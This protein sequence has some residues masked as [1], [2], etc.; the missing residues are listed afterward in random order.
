MNLCDEGYQNDPFKE[1]H[2]PVLLEML[3]I[4]YSGAG[5]ACLAVCYNKSL[6][7]SV[8]MQLDIPVPL[9]TYM[10]S[11]DQTA[12]LPSI[13]PAILKPNFGDS[14]IGIT[15][16]AVVHS[17]EELIIYMNELKNLLPNIPILVQE[18][19]TGSE[20]SVAVIGNSGNYTVLPILEVDYS[21]LP[22]NLPPILGYESKWLPDS[23]YWSCIKYKEAV[24]KEDVYAQLV[25]NAILLFERL[26]CR[27]YARFDFREDEQKNIK[28][29]EVNPNPGWCWDGKMNIMAGF[30]GLSYDQFLEL[31]LKAAIERTKPVFK[32]AT[33]EIIAT[34]NLEQK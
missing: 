19:L 12:T 16:D 23:P 29:L 4:P 15:K 34:E 13:F 17:A 28:L 25:N 3:N 9:E 20:Y 6:V 18:Y 31:I 5:P 26:E 14:S 24:L 30:K 21:R 7:R 2:I 10:G 33:P 11:S 8:A 1:L 32:G 27:D 22:A